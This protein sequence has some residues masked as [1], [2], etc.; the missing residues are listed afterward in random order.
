[1][2]FNQ[3]TP[4]LNI[5]TLVFLSLCCIGLSIY[6]QIYEEII[7]S[8]YTFYLPSLILFGLGIWSWK[9]ASKPGL[10][11]FSIVLLILNLVLFGY[12]IFLIF[13]GQP[14]WGFVT[15]GFMLITVPLNSSA[16]K[17]RKSLVGR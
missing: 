12:S 10:T 14:M 13:T 4:L 15:L 6:D 5:A 16:H 3:R 2:H 9:K 8:T 17:K 11:L 7:W 1:M